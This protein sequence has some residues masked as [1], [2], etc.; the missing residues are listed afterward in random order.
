MQTLDR[1]KDTVRCMLNLA[2][3]NAATEAE[4]ENALRFARKM[5]LE[6]HL[7]ESDITVSP[8]NI[9]DLIRSGKCGKFIAQS[10]G[11]KMY[12]WEGQLS[13]V[14]CKFVGGIKAYV[15]R[16]E[17]RRS[18]G[19]V[20]RNKNGTPQTCCVFHFY[21]LEDDAKLGAELYEE[22]SMLISTMANMQWGTCFTGAGK[23]YA[24][25]YVVGI[26]RQI[27]TVDKQITASDSRALVVRRG[28][29]VKLKESVA[30]RYLA[31]QGTR[32]AKGRGTHTGASN[33]EA[34]NQGKSDGERTQLNGRSKQI[35]QNQRLLE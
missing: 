9:E 34:Y 19:F 15:T 32:L 22:W 21:G 10:I 29:I 12:G 28:D 1:V 8:T 6:H 3:D 25:G 24:L 11:G 17:M 33:R 30:D 35:T 31:Q 5:M 18:N 7:E 16:N 13:M 23:D 20:Q 4:I 2:K 26:L 27:D 14:V